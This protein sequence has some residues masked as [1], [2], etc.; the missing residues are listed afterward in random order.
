MSPPFWVSVTEHLVLSCSY[1]A[2]KCSRSG[3]ASAKMGVAVLAV[4]SANR[5]PLVPIGTGLH[6]NSNT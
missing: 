2:A 3:N 5:V 6:F 1:R 4:V